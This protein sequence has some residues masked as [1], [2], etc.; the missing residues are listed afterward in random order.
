MANAKPKSKIRLVKPP[1]E[2]K[3]ESVGETKAA[4]AGIQKPGKVDLSKFKSK[5]TA[6]IANVGTQQGA[7][8][9]HNIAA[10][11]DF[12]RLHPDKE[13]YWSD[14]L[15]FVAVP[16]QGMKKDTLHLID[17]DLA[18]QYLPSGKVQRFRLALATKPH[19]VFFLCHV[20]T[21][22]TDN[23]WNTSNLQ[24]CEQAKAAWIQVTSR[25]HEGVESYKVDF[26]K[27]ADAFPNPKWPSQSLDD[28][29]VV[30][31]AGR[32]IDRDDHPALLRL[33]GR[34]QSV[35]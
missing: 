27:D 22:N 14:E 2:S 4:S 20:P 1:Q 23:P 3:A 29:I 17:E 28:L 5:R 6:T 34:K 13:N 19:D 33:I 35:S 18:L 10:A 8:P 7:L 32:M 12:V 26:A 31:F 21:Q 15:C 11:K 25:K 16:I 9:H 24:A 30:T